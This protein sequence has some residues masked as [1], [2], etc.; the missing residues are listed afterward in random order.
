M[1]SK[2]I[3]NVNQMPCNTFDP[4]Q[5][6]QEENENYSQHDQSISKGILIVEEVSHFNLCE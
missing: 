2:T 4:N 6:I 3:I 5:I 1:D